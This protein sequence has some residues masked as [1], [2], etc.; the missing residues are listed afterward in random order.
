MWRWKRHRQV[1]SRKLGGPYQ[2]DATLRGIQP[3]RHQIVRHF[4]R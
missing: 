3:Q 4:D 1:V 2:G